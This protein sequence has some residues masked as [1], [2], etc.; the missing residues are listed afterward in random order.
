MSDFIKLLMYTMKSFNGEQN[1]AIKAKEVLYQQILKEEYPNLRDVEVQKIGESG[2]IKKKVDH[3]VMRETYKLYQLIKIR[4]K[5]SF[6]AFK[7]R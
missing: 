2:I 1:S 4:Q 6:M 7:R 5:I 3:I